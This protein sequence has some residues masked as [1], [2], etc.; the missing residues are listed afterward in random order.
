VTAVAEGLAALGH[1]VHALVAPS[2]R[3]FPG[4]AVSWRAVRPPLGIRQLR[5]ARAPAVLHIAREIRPDVVIER[6]YNFGGEA[7]LA[8]RRLGAFSVLEVNAP[9]VDYPG[10]I[11]QR[12]DRL[13]LVQPMRRWREW[14]CRVAD[15]IVT[16]SP[17]ILPAEVPA[18]RVLPI[19]WG[20]DT[21]RF[22]PGATGTVPFS[23]DRGDTVAIF[24][25]AFRAWHGAIRLVEAI[26]TLRARGRQDIKAVLVGDGPELPRVRHASDGIDGITFTG[27]L[28]HEDVPAC[29]CAAD[30]GVAPFDVAAHP[31][32]EQEFY[33]SP[34]KIFEYM[35]SGLPVVAPRITRLESLVR[36]GR[37]GLLYDPTVADSL[38][39][40]LEQLADPGVRATLGAAARERVVREFS[41]QQHCRKLEKAIQAAQPSARPAPACAS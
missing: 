30:I 40:A 41:W 26:R 28:A 34:L 23:R 36:N 15:L 14:Q 29:L 31:A 6:Y 37:E 11:K 18:S 5:V 27:A 12:L 9:V 39:S 17:R 24:A 20:A 35:A 19:E 25:G 22:H 38:A 10:S 1:E 33:W 21:V 8:A 3:P 16:P 4:G 2:E 13:M 7:L 32:L